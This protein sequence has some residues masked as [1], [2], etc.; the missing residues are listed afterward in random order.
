M[1][2]GTRNMQRVQ[3]QSELVYL[4]L[5]YAP[6]AR[7]IDQRLPSAPTMPLRAGSSRMKR[8]QNVRWIGEVK[9]RGVPFRAGGAFPQSAKDTRSIDFWLSDENYRYIYIYYDRC[10][11]SRF[12]V[13][14]VPST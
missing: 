10:I 9:V 11:Y 7:W 3:E 5:G 1:V 2:W 6:W 8:N 12:S 13:T 14:R 4:R